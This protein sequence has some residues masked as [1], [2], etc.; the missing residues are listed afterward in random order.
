MI[1]LFDQYDQLTKDLH[2][3]LQQAGYDYPTVVLDDNGFLPDKVQSPYGY[4]L[5][6]ED[7]TSKPRFFNQIEKPTYWEIIADN[8]GAAVYDKGKKRA[9]I[10]YANQGY[11]IVR[12][13]EWLDLNEKVRSIDYYNQYGRRY[14]HTVF[15]KEQ[16]PAM[17]TYF[18]VDGQEKIVENHLTSDIILNDQ[19]QIHIFKSK[20]EFIHHYFEVAQLDYQTIL[21]NRL[22]LPFFVSYN[23]REN[24]IDILFW[25]ESIEQDIPGNMQ[26]LL[27]ETTRT[28]KIVVQNQNA[29]A[30]LTE[31]LK[32]QE[33]SVSIEPLGFIYPFERENQGTNNILIATNS[34]Q[35]EYLEELIV[36]CPQAYFHIAAI[37]EMSEKLLDKAKYANVTL[38]PNI[39][40]KRLADL[41]KTCDIYLDINHSD[42][43]MNAIREAFIHNLVILAFDN[44]VHRRDF[45]APEFIF[46]RENW[47]AMAQLVEQL[48]LDRVITQEALRRQNQTA[49]GM[50][51]A[52]YQNVLGIV[53]NEK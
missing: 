39:A 44:T 30:R 7:V 31:L 11:R 10:F 45:I 1:N 24:G 35:I 3:S 2:Y 14:A 47:Q 49:W 27:T 9:R 25:Q 40:L 22:S 26:L 20:I 41:Y 8:Q 42:E 17:T 52:D 43:L 12:T 51:A 21:Y 34:D 13:V 37:T 4:F 29:Y 23:L 28:K 15:D 38:Y 50:S 18:S 33:L 36:A 5:G 46:D 53:E 48:C 16:Q 6:T 19:K 32:D